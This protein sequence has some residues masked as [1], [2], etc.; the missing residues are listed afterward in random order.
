VLYNAKNEPTGVGPHTMTVVEVRKNRI[1]V[2][3][4]GK[5]YTMIPGTFWLVS[6]QI[7]TF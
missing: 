6:L 5:E 3:S 2:A 7:V 1:V 4:W